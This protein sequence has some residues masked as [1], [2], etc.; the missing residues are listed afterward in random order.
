[1]GKLLR[2]FVKGKMNKSVDERLL[3]DGEYV[4]ALNIRVGNTETT[5]IGSVE[6]TKGNI[7][8][9]EV[10]YQGV[11][12]SAEAVCLG[13]FEDGSNDT[14]YWMV[15]DPNNPLSPTNKYD[16]VMSYNVNDGTLTYVVQSDND[17]GAIDTALNFNPS[18]LINGINIIETQLFWTDNYNPPRTVTVNSGLGFITDK[19]FLNVIK[20]PP[21]YSP[22]LEL[23]NTQLD[24]NYLEDRMVSFA[25]RWKYKNNQYSALSPFAPIAFEPRAFRL[26]AD[27]FTNSGMQ[28]DYNQVNVDILTGDD[29]VIGMDLCFKFADDNYVR[30]AEK[31]DKQK[32]GLPDSTPADIEDG[33]P[34]YTITFDNSKT[35]TILPESEIL[36]LYDNVPRKAIAQ[37]I[38]GN[39]LMFGN[40]LEGYDLID[41]V[42]NQVWLD[43]FIEYEGL[44][45]NYNNLPVTYLSAENN[46]LGFPTPPT[47]FTDQIASFDLTGIDLNVGTQLFFRLNIEH[48]QWVQAGCAGPPA[49]PNIGSGAFSIELT[50]TLP[51]TYATV[52]DLASSDEFQSAIGQGLSGVNPNITT[53]QPLTNCAAGGTLTDVFNCNLNLA[54][55]ANW[56]GWRSGYVGVVG[57]DAIEVITSPASDEIGLRILGLNFRESSGAVLSPCMAEF[58]QIVSAEGQTQ[59]TESSQSLHSDRNYEVAMEYLDKYGRSTTA[60]V[61]E[62][63]SVYVPCVASQFKNR[64]TANIPTSQRGPEWATHY[65]FLAKPDRFLYQT[66]YATNWYTE[67]GTNDTWIQLEGEN[68]LK[69]EVGDFLRVKTDIGGAIPQ[70]CIVEVLDKQN[71]QRNFLSGDD[72][73]APET[74]YE[75]QGVYMKVKPNCFDTAKDQTEEFTNGLIK[76]NSKKD[77]DTNG[78]NDGS[79]GKDYLFINYECFDGS[80]ASINPW[81]ID[82]GDQVQLLVEVYR[83]PHKKCKDTCGAKLTLMDVQITASADYTNVKEFFE[84]EGLPAAWANSPDQTVDCIDDSGSGIA[85]YYPDLEIGSGAPGAFT[86]A[87]GSDSSAATPGNSK[88]QFFA[89]PNGP[90]PD[91]LIMRIVG[92]YPYCSGRK[93]GNK[94]EAQIIITRNPNVLCFETDPIDANADLYYEGS[95]TYKLG[96]NGEHLGITANGDTNQDFATSQS[97][98]INLDFFNCYAFGNGVESFR[99]LDSLSQQYFLLG[100]RTNAVAAE[101][102]KETRRFADI[103]YSGTFNTESNV[104]RLNEFNLGLSNFKPLEQAFGDIGIIDARETDLLVLQEDK[105]SYVLLG[106]NLLS[107]STGGGPVTSVPEV[108]GTQIARV[109][110]FGISFNPE[111]YVQW[112][113]EKYFTDAKRGAVIRLTGVGKSEQLTPISDMGMDSWFRDLFQDSFYTQKL[114]GYDPYMDEYVLGSNDNLVPRD[115]ECEACGARKTITVA[116]GVSVQFCIDYGTAVGTAIVNYVGTPESI[117]DVDVDYNGVTTSFPGLTG[118]GAFTFPKDVPFVET[119]TFTITGANPLA[120]STF[121]FSFPCPTGVE[122]TVISVCV[123]SDTQTGQSIHNQSNYDI[124]GSYF[125]TENNAV[126]FGAGTLPIVSQYTQ[127]AGLQGTP[128]IPTDGSTVHMYARKIGSDNFSFDPAQDN[129]KWLLSNTLYANNVTDINTL[130]GL[131]DPAV[132]PAC[133]PPTDASAAPTTYQAEFTLPPVAGNDYLY[134]IYDYRKSTAIELCYDAAV[135]YDVCCECTTCETVTAFLA[136]GPLDY[137]AV[138]PTSGPLNSTFYWS[139]TGTEPEVGDPVFN[140]AAG[141]VNLGTGWYKIN[142]PVTGPVL[143]IDITGANSV[144]QLKQLC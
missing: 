92:G 100:A 41:N 42:G 85:T 63:N 21:L 32:L 14:I 20:A 82:E 120:A 93:K 96:P 87:P 81:I 91:Y 126:I 114:G 84:G 10:L 89:V 38:M 39:R 128:L 103:T 99:V 26:N 46:I 65:R 7:K 72:P 124:G 104:N 45:I 35:Y 4:D 111:S 54:P 62:N 97:A 116:N 24:V 144:V 12:L 106:K 49:P 78:V 139:G 143:F 80:G 88:I 2:T 66:I 142:D 28:N 1:M 134:L 8:L 22:T 43:Y 69:V 108:L 68:Q 53:I 6:K 86:I 112:G 59:S 40:Y 76:V 9:T 16:C 77:K 141:T 15:H 64:L 13:A 34:N 79:G 33:V 67:V 105:I 36:R 51:T 117:V 131:V 31:V 133:N 29:T 121:S 44:A 52:F 109:E 19:D 71:Q 61:S 125:S 118:S 5:E 115:V 110:E 129:F 70:C 30:I 83:E 3:P 25:Y 37:T 58:F 55:D 113:A 95:Q 73:A 137:A 60:L 50:W 101:E 27:N 11:A 98:L 17:G 107:D 122:L 74:T 75:R 123:T 127:V 90:D 94:L 48:S 56:A 138:C 132:C 47:T 130:L 135:L 136:D 18:Y 119:A 102:Y 140:D 23:E 57:G